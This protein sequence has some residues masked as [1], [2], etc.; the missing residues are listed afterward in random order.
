[1]LNEGNI[2]KNQILIYLRRLKFTK[3]LKTINEVES[4]NKNYIVNIISKVIK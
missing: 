2:I 1:M 4:L 3:I